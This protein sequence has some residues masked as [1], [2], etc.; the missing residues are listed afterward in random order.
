[1]EAK[2]KA[3]TIQAGELSLV[4]SAQTKEPRAELASEEN[5]SRARQN[6]PRNAM[7]QNRSREQQ[8]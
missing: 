8:E 5:K 2:L 7:N 6:T 1:V 4:R 3:E